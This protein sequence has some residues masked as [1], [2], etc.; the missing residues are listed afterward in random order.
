MH[1][2]LFR[3]LFTMYYYNMSGRQLE[4]CIALSPMMLFLPSSS[5]Y[6]YI[7]VQ[8]ANWGTYYLASSLVYVKLLWQDFWPFT[9]VY[10][11]PLKITNFY[12]ACMVPR[13][14]HKLY[15]NAHKLASVLL[16]LSRF[17]MQDLI[18]VQITKQSCKDL[19]RTQ[20]YIICIS[21]IHVFCKSL[22][23]A[24]CYYIWL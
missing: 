18:L 1:A 22:H 7:L 8:Q 13:L 5:Q 21:K 10:C 23:I 2:H 15:R 3:W 19:G 6:V 24:I 4:R 20:W 9:P 16:L 14:M 17:V 11:Y 12:C